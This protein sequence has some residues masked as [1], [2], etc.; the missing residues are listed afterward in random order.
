[1]PVLAVCLSCLSVCPCRQEL[2]ERCDETAKDL[3]EGTTALRSTI[4]GLAHK[5]AATSEEINRACALDKK[6]WLG[7]VGAL[8]TAVEGE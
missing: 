7:K 3:L 8:E 2:T 4:E 6:E 1:M 5:V